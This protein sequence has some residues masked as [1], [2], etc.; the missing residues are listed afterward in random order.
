MNMLWPPLVASVVLAAYV[1]I[2][3]FDRVDGDER[4]Y[5][6]DNMVRYHSAAIE[7]SKAGATVLNPDIA[8]FVS[9]LNWKSQEVFDNTDR[10]W[11]ITYMASDPASQSTMISEVAV[12]SIPYELARTN[13]SGGTYGMWN[14]NILESTI[15]EVLFTS[16]PSG[17]PTVPLIP[18]GTPVIATLF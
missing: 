2:A 12:A 10:R 1:A 8:P 9:V 3:S 16:V 13:F 17:R 15:G 4:R 11:V 5:A 18:D 7:L 6:A 14:D